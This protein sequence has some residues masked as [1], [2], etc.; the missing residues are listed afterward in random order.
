VMF[1]DVCGK[2]NRDEQELSLLQQ[3]GFNSVQICMHSSLEIIS[4]VNTIVHATGSRREWLGAWWF[5]LYYVFNAALVISACI[6]VDQKSGITTSGSSI[7]EMLDQPQKPLQ[8]AVDTLIHLDRGNR[9]IDTCAAFLKRLG[10]VVSTLT[11]ESSIDVSI[12]TSF[13]ESEATFFGQQG[14]MMQMPAQVGITTYQSPLGMD[15]GEFMESDLDF[16][17]YFAI[18][19]PDSALPNGAHM[20]I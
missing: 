17:N 3:I 10:I 11:S 12:P 2:T 7:P 14:E 15:L 13:L 1:L 18:N 6:V 8:T 20:Q 5:S 19:P 4:I 9:M 16:L